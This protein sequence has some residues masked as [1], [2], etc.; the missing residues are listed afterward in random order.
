M[1]VSQTKCGHTVDS[2]GIYN[3]AENKRMAIAAYRAAYV[4]DSII[5]L[6]EKEAV[7]HRAANAKLQEANA[8]LA[9]AN[10]NNSIA[11][12]AEKPKKWQ[13]G[14]VGLVFGFLIGKI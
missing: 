12:A 4:R 7:L 2:T 11:L 6:Q 1:Q 14:G 10:T 3:M 13:W 8:T 9:T 5:D